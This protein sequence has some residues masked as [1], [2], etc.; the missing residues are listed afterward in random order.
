MRKEWVSHFTL[1]KLLIEPILQEIFQTKSFFLFYSILEAKE[2]IEQFSSSDLFQVTQNRRER[3]RETKIIPLHD[4]SLFFL[5][6]DPIIFHPLSFF[7]LS[8]SAFISSFKSSSCFS[9]YMT[10]DLCHKYQD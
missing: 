3:E 1:D 4:G 8:L 5:H 6:F 2:K 10:Q 9:R 7:I